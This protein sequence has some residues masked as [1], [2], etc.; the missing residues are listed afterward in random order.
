M[1]PQVKASSVRCWDK[2]MYG[3]EIRQAFRGRIEMEGVATCQERP[4]K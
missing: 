1:L 2:P 4:N 3:L